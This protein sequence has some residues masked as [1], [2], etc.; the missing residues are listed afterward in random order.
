MS[1]KEFIRKNRK[2]IDEVIRSICPNCKFNDKERENWIMHDEEL[3]R[4]ARRSEV[5]I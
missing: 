2:E 5:N 1:K 3:Y 4:W